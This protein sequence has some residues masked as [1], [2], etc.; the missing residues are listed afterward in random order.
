M[1]R[2]HRSTVRAPRVMAEVYRMLLD[3]MVA[4]GWD[5]PRRRARVNRLHLI[6]ILLRHAIF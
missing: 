1:D 4:W 5:A 3:R 2:A 6:M